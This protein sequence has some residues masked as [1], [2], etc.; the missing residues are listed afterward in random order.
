MLDMGG[1]VEKRGVGGMEGEEE[2]EG[3]GQGHKHE[4]HGMARHGMAPH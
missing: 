3:H 2:E 1:L 4:G